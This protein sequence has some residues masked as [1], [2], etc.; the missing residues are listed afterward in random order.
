M[1]PVAS[2]DTTWWRKTSSATPSVPE[3]GAADRVVPPEV[4]R[5]PRDRHAARLEQIRLVGE[6]ERQRRVLLDEEHADVLVTVDRADDTE[7]LA[8]DE[9]REPERRLVEQQE[10]RPPHDA[11]RHPA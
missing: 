6:V 8:D 3:V 7:D 11:P 4:R 10:P 5:G 2:R 1:R 9:R